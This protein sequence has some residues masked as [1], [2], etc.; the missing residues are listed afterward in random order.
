QPAPAESGD[1][2]GESAGE[3]TAA[4]PDQKIVVLLIVEPSGKAIAGRKI[5][6]ALRDQG[7]EFGEREIYH[8]MSATDPV[9]SVAGL[10]KP[11]TLDPQQADQF[12]APGLSVFMVLPG[13]VPPQTALRDMVET[14]RRIAAKLEARVFNSDK[15]PLENEA[16]SAL[17][18]DVKTW[19]EAKGL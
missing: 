15:Q 6:D 17:G 9:F 11:G 5:H 16:L 13:P 1:A 18:D 14:A 12:S 2:T 8:R 19:A 10:L 3:V 7:L 4:V